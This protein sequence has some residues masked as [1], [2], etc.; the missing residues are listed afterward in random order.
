[1]R[2][3]HQDRHLDL[4][5]WYTLLPSTGPSQE[6][7][8]TQQVFQAYNESAVFLAFHPE[9]ALD[10]NNGGKLPLTIYESVWEVKAT[11]DASEDKAMTDSTEGSGGG[12]QLKFREIPYSVEVEETEMISMN[13]IAGSSGG[14][15]TTAA[16]A[17]ANAQSA[18]ANK[19][20][21]PSRSI[22]SNGKGKRRLV[23]KGAEAETAAAAAAAS[24]DYLT[25]D[26]EEMVAFL[27]TKANAI[28]MLQSRIR[29]IKTYLENL[30]P[31]ALTKTDDV[32]MD[33]DDATNAAATTTTTTSSPITASLTVLRQIQAL[34]SR[35]DLIVPSDK[36]TFERELAEGVNDAKLI[37]LMDQIAR[38]A[39]Q[40]RVTGK[41]FSIV[42]SAKSSN[43]HRRG[44]NMG[45]YPMTTDFSS[46]GVGDIIM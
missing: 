13:Y 24:G 41:K 36:E 25:T 44:P 2:Q 30:P 39:N 12:P 6:S 45:E 34:V 18:L 4:V 27:T 35:L 42:E 37:M 1:M 38:S 26:E 40:A 17:A 16:A 5:G 46:L 7:R 14:T 19:D 10:P 28:K 22:E 21:K 33:A 29:L 43:N 31:S 32:N 11:A 3:V 15:T 9:H 20:D 8:F 23:E